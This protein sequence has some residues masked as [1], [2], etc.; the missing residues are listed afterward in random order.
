MMQKVGKHI[1]DFGFKPDE[2]ARTA[3]LLE[4]I[5]QF[6]ARKAGVH[7][8]RRWQIWNRTSK[9]VKEFY[10]PDEVKALLA[11]YVG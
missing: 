9:P 6:T 8:G 2:L 1:E 3:Q 11:Q 4:V 7:R 5:I 10:R